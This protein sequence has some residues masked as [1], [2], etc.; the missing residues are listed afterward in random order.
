LDSPAIAAPYGKDAAW[1]G[2]LAFRSTQQIG[3]AG[4]CIAESR[5]LVKAF[6]EPP[7]YIS[8]DQ[9]AKPA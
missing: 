3:I 9:A 5:I 6:R 1:W 4:C 8:L 7:M 2:D